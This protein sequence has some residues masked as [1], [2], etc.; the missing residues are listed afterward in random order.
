MIVQSLFIL[1]LILPLLLAIPLCLRKSS[2]TGL[3]VT[4]AYS[5]FHAIA[6][7]ILVFQPFME[8][9]FSAIT[10]TS[11]F[12]LDELNAPFLPIFSLVLM[13]VSFYN[14]GFSEF[15][16]EYNN[17]SNRWYYGLFLLL[18]AGSINGILL[19]AHL[20][21]LW[22]FVEAS[23]L[24]SSVLIYYYGK[25]TTIEAVWKYVFICSIGISFVF[26]GIILLSVSAGDVKSLFFVDLNKS[27]ASLNIFWL[28]LSIPFLLIGF[29]TKVGLAPMHNWLPDAHSEAPSPVSAMLSAA[30][31][32]GAFLGILRVHKIMTLAGLI[33]Y[34]S[35]LLLIMGFLSL[36]IS[37]VFIMNAR[38]YKRMLAYSSIEHMAIA[39]IGIALG[40]PAIFAAFLHIA[41]HSLGKAAFFLNSGNVYSLTHTKKIKNVSGLFSSSAPTAWLW[42][43]SF[44]AICAFPPFCTF[45]S[46]F[47]IIREMMKHYPLLTVFFL[48]FLT[49]IM[50]GMARNVFKMVSGQVRPES[51]IKRE[52]FSLL[53]IIPQGTLLLCA[54]VLGLWMPDSIRLLLSKAA[55]FIGG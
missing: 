31:L 27:A 40:G 3:I 19:S 9:G 49:L 22:V 15:K 41:G 47:M 32:N 6:S 29:G 16:E 30:L 46:E 50:F 2:R 54:V 44:L 18:F 53:C 13:A 26:I 28:K 7:F 4:A 42:I 25:R 34:S 45:V 8:G 43:F 1:I 38:N 48:I 20:G 51:S 5:V 33:S 12:V 36:F 14:L 11:Y 21:L 39:A 37:A 10:F 23:T 24:T 17:Q 55:A 35:I 52:K